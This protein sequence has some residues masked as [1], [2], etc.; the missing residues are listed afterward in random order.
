MP[1]CGAL[2]I[3]E[4]GQDLSQ[5]LSSW[6]KENGHPMISVKDLKD[7]F[8]TLQKEKVGVL[9][10]DVCLPQA[11]GYETISIIKSLC[12][13]LPIIITAA[14]NNPEQEAQIRQKGIF[15]YHVKSFGLEEL[16]LAISNAMVRSSH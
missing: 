5:G 6:A 13:R 16:I 8:L 10:M 7:L 1:K 2:L 12:Q 4:P 15:Y 11:L 3:A 9:V 14:E